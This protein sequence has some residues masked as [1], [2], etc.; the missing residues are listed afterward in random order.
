MDFFSSLRQRT[1]M[2]IVTCSMFLL[3]LAFVLLIFGENLTSHENDWIHAAKEGT[4]ADL[5]YVHPGEHSSGH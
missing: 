3:S 2:L 5:L 1:K 4:R